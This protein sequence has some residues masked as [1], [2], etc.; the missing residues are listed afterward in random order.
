MSKKQL[1]AEPNFII[2]LFRFL[3][4]KVFFRN[5][6]F[7]GIFLLI[8]F[9]ALN[10]YLRSY[11]NHSQKLTLPDFIDTHITDA[12]ELA[13]EKSFQII[14][15]DSTHI[16]GQRGGMIINQNPRALSQVKENRKVY[17]TVTK[18]LSDQIRL[19]SLPE[20][21]GREFEQKKKELALMKINSRVKGYAYDRGE[22]DHVLEVYYN[23]KMIVDLNG[24]KENVKIE[25]GGTLEFVLS[26]RSGLE[27]SMPDLRCQ[28]LAAAQFMIEEGSRLNIG[29]ISEEGEIE[30][31]SSSYIIGQY[32]PY[33]DGAKI[34]IGESIDVVVSAEK[35]E[36]CN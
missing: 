26:E 12:H 21:Y 7:M 11:T 16:V 24:R 36:D 33:S 29:K 19:S 30:D 10:L 5:L 2:K 27:I 4:N 20:L 15:N 1:K 13:E 22:P 35:P 32:P 14:V 9:I 17:V 6:L 28:T 8:L 3:T 18:Y 31:A 25:K 34:Y 23:D